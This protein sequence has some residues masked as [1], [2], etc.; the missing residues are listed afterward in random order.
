MV[1]AQPMPLSVALGFSLRSGQS[2]PRPAKEM[3]QAPFSSWLPK[4]TVLYNRI[5]FTGCIFLF[6][7]I[8]YYLIL[9]TFF[10]KIFI[11]SCGSGLHLINPLFTRD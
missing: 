2:Y 9:Y 4:E 11:M 10:V 6:I 7:I 3:G 5:I 1:V 8:V